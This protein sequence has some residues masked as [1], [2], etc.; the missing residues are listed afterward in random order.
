MEKAVGAS[1]EEFIKLI[2]SIFDDIIT[3]IEGMSDEN[4]QATFVFACAPNKPELTK[5]EGYHFIR[6]H[7]TDHRGQAIA[8]L[9][10]KGHSVPSYRP[11]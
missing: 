4:L 11:F 1:K 10:I 5:E 3:T 8:I 9:R 2:N 7:I 6:D